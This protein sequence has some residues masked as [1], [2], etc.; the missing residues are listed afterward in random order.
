M[1]GFGTCP[2]V[3]VMEV[4]D[5][6]SFIG[7]WY[8]VASYPDKMMLDGRCAVTTFTLPMLDVNGSSSEISLFRKF[9][10]FGKEKKYLGSATIITAGVL[11][12]TYPASREFIVV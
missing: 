11:G 7:T 10:S 4:F 3:K 9:I 2:R 6:T 8:F 12:V 1:P 5:V